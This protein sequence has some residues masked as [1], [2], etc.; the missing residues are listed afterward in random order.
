MLSE[1]IGQVQARIY[2]LAGEDTF[3]INST[4]QLGQVLFE[5]LGLPP[6]KKTKTGYSTNVEV[7][8]KLR[9]KHPIID[10]IMDY[11]QLAKLKSTYVDG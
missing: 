4:Q 5:R 8:E 3:N 7:L 2:D 10:V 11:R 1:R 9:G 6:V